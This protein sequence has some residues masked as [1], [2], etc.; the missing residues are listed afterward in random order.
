MSP[1]V[2]E[3]Y[4]KKFSRCPIPVNAHLPPN[5]YFGSIPEKMSARIGSFLEI[6][7]GISGSKDIVRYLTLRCQ[8]KWRTYVC[9][10]CSSAPLFESLV[11]FKCLRALAEPGEAVGVLAGQVH[12]FVCVLT[13]SL[14]CFLLSLS[15]CVYVS[16]ACVHNVHA[17]VCV[18]CV[19]VYVHACICVCVCI[20]YVCACVCAYWVCVRVVCVYVRACVCA[21]VYCVCV[22]I[23]YVH[24]CVCVY[25]VCV[26]VCVCVF[27][28]LESRPLK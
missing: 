16:S 13:S 28:P 23:C 9:V 22:C 21:C 7:S 6:S 2:R 10:L 4:S 26:C 5:R 19:H 15:V 17:C 12:R 1:M 24:A 18:C 20:C 14:L 11:H 8:Q 3:S 25:C 27:S